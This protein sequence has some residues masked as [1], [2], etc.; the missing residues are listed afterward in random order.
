MGDTIILVNPNTSF[1]RSRTG[2][3]MDLR[4]LFTD[5]ATKQDPCAHIMDMSSKSTLHP[6]QVVEPFLPTSS[7]NASKALASSYATAWMQ[8]QS[9][10]PGTATT[11][12]I[13]PLGISASLAH[14]GS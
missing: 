10:T 13:E 6:R 11:E 12:M 14:R 3:L 9:L 5:M 4:Q 1:T 7:D 2:A 8:P